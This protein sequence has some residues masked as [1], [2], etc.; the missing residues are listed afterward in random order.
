MCVLILLAT[1]FLF[2]ANDKGLEWSSRH[3]QAVD[4]TTTSV[5]TVSVCDDVVVGTSNL[6]DNADGEGLKLLHGVVYCLQSLVSEKYVILWQL[7]AASHKS[8]QVSRSSKGIVESRLSPALVSH[9]TKSIARL[10]QLRRSIAMAVVSCVRPVV[11]AT[12]V[13][14]A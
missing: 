1:K 13:V 8:W 7:A 11:V 12:G 6:K 3:L 5:F 9:S 4:C 2:H 14:G 10:C